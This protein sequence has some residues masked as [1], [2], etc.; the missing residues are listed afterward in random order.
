M[1]DRLLDGIKLSCVVFFLY[2]V[3]VF[4]ENDKKRLK[5]NQHHLQIIENNSNFF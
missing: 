5:L 4:V 2:E 1:Y 3:H